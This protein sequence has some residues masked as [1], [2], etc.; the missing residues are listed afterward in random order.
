MW[1]IFSWNRSASAAAQAEATCKR[2]SNPNLKENVIQAENPGPQ[3]DCHGQQEG[4]SGNAAGAE[5]VSPVQHEQ[6]LHEQ[7]TLAKNE[8]VHVSS[9]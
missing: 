1:N 6:H 9:L 2:K 4:H 5:T 3:L 8:V 7:V